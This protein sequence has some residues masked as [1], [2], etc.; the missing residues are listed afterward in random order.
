M[1]PGTEQMFSTVEGRIE[2]INSGKCV[3]QNALKIIF[4]STAGV[5]VMPRSRGKGFYCKKFI[6]KIFMECTKGKQ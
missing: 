6:L 2:Y 3:L 4:L 1:M 5:M